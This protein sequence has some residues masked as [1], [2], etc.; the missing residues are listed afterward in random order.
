MGTIPMQASS[1]LQHRTESMPNLDEE[2][3]QY[4]SLPAGGGVGGG[5]P[6][7]V[8]LALPTIIRVP[9]RCLLA[10]P[11]E[12]QNKSTIAATVP[13]VSATAQRASSARDAEGFVSYFDPQRQVQPEKYGGEISVFSREAYIEILARTAVDVSGTRSPRLCAIVGCTRNYLTPPHSFPIEI[14]APS[15]CTTCLG[16]P[17]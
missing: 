6:L 10:G 7:V 15:F 1:M 16:S 14:D 9:I 13:S 2:E 4:W 8:S 11:L 3:Q 12:E 17:G 5:N